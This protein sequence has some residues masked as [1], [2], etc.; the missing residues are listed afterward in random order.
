MVA[1]IRNLAGLRRFDLGRLRQRLQASRRLRRAQ[2]YLERVRSGACGARH[3][4]RSRH[5]LDGQG[6]HRLRPAGEGDVRRPATAGCSTPSSRFSPR[7]ARPSKSRRPISFR[8]TAGQG[9]CSGSRARASRSRCSPTRSPRP[10]SLRCMAA[11]CAFASRWSPAESGF[12]SCAPATAR[13]TCRCSARAAPAC[14][15]R[16]SWSTGFGLRRLVQLRPPLGVAQHGNGHSV[17]ACGTRTRDAGGLRRGNRSQAQLQG[18][19][20][21]RTHRLAGRGRRAFL[22]SEPEASLRRRAVA[23]LISLLPVESQL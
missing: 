11:T 14:T 7:R 19:A 12:S 16:P 8:W 6:E 4:V 1:P 21:R 10:T 23:A 13:K 17:R 3:D 15:P 2:P 5:A 22:D 9:S 20:P 18:G